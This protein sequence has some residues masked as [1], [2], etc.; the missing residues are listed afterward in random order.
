MSPESELYTRAFWKA[1]FARAVSAS[2]VAT[3]SVL[4]S[5][6]L[7][8]IKSAP[9]Y[10]VLSTAILSFLIVMGGL[11]GGAGIRDA[12]P[13]DVTTRQA[14]TTLRSTGRHAKPDTNRE[15]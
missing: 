4:A 2:A 9:W 8:A 5:V 7:D 14:L 15:G 10:G 3:T 11:I 6:Q 12:V 1:A 13:G